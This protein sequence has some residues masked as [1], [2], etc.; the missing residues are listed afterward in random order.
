MTVSTS[1]VPERI[2]ANAVAARIRYR[3][4]KRKTGD[5]RQGRKGDVVYIHDRYRG[6]APPSGPP[7]NREGGVGQIIQVAVGG[8]AKDV[9]REGIAR[10]RVQNRDRNVGRGLAGSK[11]DGQTVGL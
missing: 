9:Q 6:T 8:I 5:G 3:G 2:L 1:A 4:H 7:R 11:C 10:P